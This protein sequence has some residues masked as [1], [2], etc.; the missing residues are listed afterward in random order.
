MKITSL[1]VNNVKRIK[2]VSLKLDKAGNLV[3]IGGR[4]EQGKTSVLDSICMAWMGKKAIPAKPVH[5]GA[6]KGTILLETEEFVVERMI[7]DDSTEL[8]V[9]DTKGLRQSSPQALLDR[10]YGAL[11]FDPLAF[12]N[13]KP[14]DQGETYKD[15]VGLNLEDIDNEYKLTF[16]ERTQTNRELKSIQAQLDVASHYQDAPDNEV[17]IAELST[18]LQKAT[19]NNWTIKQKQDRK[20]QLI[21]D[22][23]NVKKTL[24]NLEHELKSIDTIL[25][26]TQMIDTDSISAKINSSKEQNRKYHENVAYVKLRKQRDRLQSES[27]SYTNSL[28][29][30]KSRKE[31]RLTSAKSPLPELIYSEEYGIT[32]KGIPFSQCS[33]AERLRVSVAMGLAMNPELKVLLIRDGSLLD[34][35]HLEQIRDLAEQNDAQIWI[36]R[37]GEGKECSVIIE[38]GRVKE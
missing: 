36:E 16:D 5:D 11:T 1:S 13:M 30:L 15:V 10:F 25:A 18:R 38:D 32:Y 7:K 6:S 26:D 2:A 28:E 3:I 19:A 33:S 12:S 24:E 4:N 21:A 20:T 35:E 9:R 37:V 17:D 29:E 31:A 14:K 23:A 8:V 27:D 34:D 22:I